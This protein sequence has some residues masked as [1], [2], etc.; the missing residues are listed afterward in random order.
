MS[1]SMTIPI[2][3]EI[4]DWI[5]TNRKVVNE[6]PIEWHVWNPGFKQVV[7]AYDNRFMD[8]LNRLDLELLQRLKINISDVLANK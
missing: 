7:D 1:D 6:S 4:I 3:P 8:G 5:E 2:T